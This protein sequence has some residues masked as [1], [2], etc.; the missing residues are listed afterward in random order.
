MLWPWA[1]EKIC[2]SLIGLEKS[3][4]K[5]TPEAVGVGVG[6]GEGV[7]DGVGEGDGPGEL[8]DV[9]DGEDEVV[10]QDT[11]NVSTRTTANRIHNRRN[12]TD[13]RP[14][15]VLTLLH[16]LAPAENRW[17]VPHLRPS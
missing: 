16:S 9:G 13:G 6:W 14:R 8:E 12:D 15:I 2:Q 7:G 11:V 3:S 1:L 17:N 4:K 10:A 5:R